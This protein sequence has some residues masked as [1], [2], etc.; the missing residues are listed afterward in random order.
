MNRIISYKRIGAP[1]IVAYQMASVGER[2]F[3]TWKAKGQQVMTAMSEAGHDAWENI[4]MAAA[5]ILHMSVKDQK[6]AKLIAQDAGEGLTWGEA[7]GIALEMLDTDAA[8]Y[9]E[10]LVEA[11]KVIG[12]PAF[13]ADVFVQFVAGLNRA[14]SESE[15][16][17]I[18]TVRFNITHRKNWVAAMTFLERRFPERWRRRSDVHVDPEKPQAQDHQGSRKL[19]KAILQSKEATRLH[20]EALIAAG[21]RTIA[22]IASGSSDEG[23]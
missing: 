3:Y 14:E 12:V 20:N 6:K 18:S 17:A 23:H 7:R 2:T 1:D 8:V 13:H 16:E 9:F 10:E 22:R 19:A 21:H 4:S 11:S 5:D 15:L